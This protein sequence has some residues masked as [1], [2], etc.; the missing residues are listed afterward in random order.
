MKKKR[1][2]AYFFDDAES[3]SQESLN[4]AGIDADTVSKHIESGTDD[5][6]FK[7]VRVAMDSTSLSYQNRWQLMYMC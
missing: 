5:R 3:N 7:G 2:T 4:N 6:V 1:A